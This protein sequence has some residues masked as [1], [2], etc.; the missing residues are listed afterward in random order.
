MKANNESE[1]FEWCAWPALLYPART[2]IAFAFIGLTAAIVYFL[3]WSG[4]TVFYVLVLVLS[5]HGHFV[6]RRY[7]LDDEGVT[8][9]TLGIKKFR[10]WE[11]FRSYYADDM[12]V[13]LSTFTYPSPLDSFRGT[14]L[15]VGREQRAAVIAFIQSRLPH[16]V[17]RKKAPRGGKV[18]P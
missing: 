8:V 4:W 9:W 7:R 1:V 13:M 16:A 14:N 3:M 10:P 17:D 2:A 11:F 6:P 12:G 15:R 18:A 5:L